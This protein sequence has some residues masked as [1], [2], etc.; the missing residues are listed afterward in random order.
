MPRLNNSKCLQHEAQRSP[1]RKLIKW[2]RVLLN[3]TWTVP[4]LNNSKCLQHEYLLYFS[5]RWPEGNEWLVYL[6]YDEGRICVG[7]R[8][9][10]KVDIKASVAKNNCVKLHHVR[11][12]SKFRCPNKIKNGDYKK[13][14]H[15]IYSLSVP[16]LNL[17]GVCIHTNTSNIADGDPLWMWR[18][19]QEQ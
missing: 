4:R 14:I 11:F 18:C 6:Q 9:H 19:I 15:I 10:V 12:V 16:R 17:T 8:G 13:N 1:N 3:K 5:C 7:D 2:S